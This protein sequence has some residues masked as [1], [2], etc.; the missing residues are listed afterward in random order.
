MF[1][2]I[3]LL[4]LGL[5]ILLQRLGVIHGGF[6]GFLWPAVLVAVGVYLI[7]KNRSKPNQ[8]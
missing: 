5:L 6:W 1:M 8:L 7:T 2:G 3:L 4:L